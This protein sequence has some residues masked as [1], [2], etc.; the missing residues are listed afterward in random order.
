MHLIGR[1]IATFSNADRIL[2]LHTTPTTTLAL[3]SITSLFSLPPSSGE[4]ECIFG[5]TSDP[6]PSILHIHATLEPTPS[7]H[8]LSNTTLPL[9]SPPAFILPVDPMAWSGN[10]GANGVH[11]VLLSVGQDG[12]L[13]FWLPDENPERGWRSTGH[14]KTGR[15]GITLARCSSAK[16][17]ALGAHIFNKNRFI[18][19]SL[20]ILFF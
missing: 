7:L 1:T 20:F 10:E 15:A 11:D 3:P 6:T 4:H 17:S 18:L 19:H 13:M 12:Q 9:P 5:V 14:V 2:T 8:L 16:K